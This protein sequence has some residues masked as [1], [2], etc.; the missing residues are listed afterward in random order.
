[1]TL[2]P[3]IAIIVIAARL[4]GAAAVR[5]GQPRILGELLAGMMLGPSLLGGVWPDASARIGPEVTSHLKVLAD[6]GLVLFMFLVGLE[7]DMDHLRRQGRKVVL[8]SQVSIAVPMVLGGLVGLCLYEQLDPPTR[9]LGFVLFMGVAMSITAFPVLARLLEDTGLLH[10]RTG[11]LALACAAIDDVSAWCLLAVVVALTGT[12]SAVEVI[13][14]LALVVLYGAVMW[15]VA[16]PLVARCRRVPP[17]A[18]VALAV[19]SAWTTDQIGVHAIF[20]AFAA[21]AILPSRDDVSRELTRQ[22]RPVV[23]HVLLPVY[24]VTVGMAT[25][26]GTLD[27]V[28]MWLLCGL[29]LATAI[30]AKFGGATIAARLVGERWRTAALIGILMNTRG[31]TE[32]VIL[33]VGMELG[34]LTDATFTMM[35]IMALTTTFLAAPLLKLVGLPPVGEGATHR[36]SVRQSNTGWP[37]PMRCPS[38]SR[39]QAARSPEAPED[40]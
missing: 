5:F 40:P 24:F 6:L 9:R 4:L 39:I 36:R 2:L 27:S 29:V 16:R 30:S 22:L 20:G 11:A 31:L 10:T 19:A 26:V 13:A 23:N 17:W 7:L 37:M 14:T 12:G 35:V 33:T 25:R 8:I 32:I 3:T 15:T 34:V 28:R 38:L 1:M 18:A 21:G